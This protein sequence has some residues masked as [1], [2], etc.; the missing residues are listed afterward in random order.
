[1]VLAVGALLLLPIPHDYF[2]QQV[3]RDKFAHLRVGSNPAALISWPLLWFHHFA[4]PVLAVACVVGAVLAWRKSVNKPDILALAAWT[5]IPMAA[6]TVI[7][8]RDDFYLAS[9]VPAT[10]VLAG[11]GFAALKGKARNVT[12]VVMMG[13]L[14]GYWVWCVT[15]P[16]SRERSGRVRQSLRRQTRSFSLL[17]LRTVFLS[18]TGNRPVDR[19]ALLR[20]GP[21]GRHSRGH[22][23]RRR[24][25]V[26]PVGGRSFHADRRRAQGTAARAETV[27]GHA[28]PRRKQSGTHAASRH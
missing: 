9:V 4:G 26:R 12:A 20:E 24:R 1:M 23:L 19:R 10:Y 13:A 28:L 5:V 16:A 14:A 21:P 3:G 18:A 2:T 15:T 8:K 22:A 7:N 11:L 6:L 17:A 25:S 27:F